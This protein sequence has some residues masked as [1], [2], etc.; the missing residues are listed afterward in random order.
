MPFNVLTMCG[1]NRERFLPACA[2]LKGVREKA[3][4]LKGKDKIPF[5]LSFL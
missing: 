4:L 1:Q 2:L 3:E 5:Q